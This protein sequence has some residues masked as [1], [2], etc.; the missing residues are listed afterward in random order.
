MI[1]WNLK[2]Q[3]MRAI[4]STPVELLNKMWS[5]TEAGPME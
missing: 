5:V 1:I 3:D 2:Y 4:R